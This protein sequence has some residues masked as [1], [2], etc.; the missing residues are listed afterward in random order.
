MVT[1]I[2]AITSHHRVIFINLEATFQERHWHCEVFLH[3]VV[4]SPLL[5]LSLIG[6]LLFINLI[7]HFVL[8]FHLLQLSLFLPL[9]LIRHFTLLW[10]SYLRL[11]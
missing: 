9:L 6:F 8:V 2:L 10:L 7:N 1:F 5:I 3:R 4:K 11:Q